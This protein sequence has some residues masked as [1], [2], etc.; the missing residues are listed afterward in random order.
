LLLPAALRKTHQQAEVAHPLLPACRCR[1]GQRSPKGPAIGAEKGREPQGRPRV[2]IHGPVDDKDRVTLSGHRQPR[3]VL[4]QDLG[5][6]SDELRL[7]CMIIS[8]R[9]DATQSRARLQQHVT[10]RPST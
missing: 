8:L 10:W 1:P 4:S 5:R 9:S 3:V 7:E 2:R 6:A